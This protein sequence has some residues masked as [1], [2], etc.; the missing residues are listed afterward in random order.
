VGRCRLTEKQHSPLSVKTMWL[1]N[2]STPF[3][4]ERT[5]V[6]DQDGAEIWLVAVKGTFIIQPDGKQVLDPKQ[7][8]V[9]RIPVFR[10][11]PETSSLLYECDLLHTKSRT[12]VFVDGH[13]YG[14]KG[15]PVTCM[16]VRLKV[17]NLDKRLRVY[18]DRRWDYGLTDVI[19]SDPEPFTKVPIIYERAFGGTD[20]KSPD[21]KEHRWVAEN[22]VGKGFAT[23]KE[24]IVGQQAPNIEDPSV[25]YT[26]W[27]EGRTI[28][29]GPIARHWSPRL[30]LAGTYDE[31][32]E[33]TRKPLLPSDFD[34]LFYQCAPVD[35]QVQDFLRG[36][37]LVELWNMTESGYL[38]FRLPKVV[39]GFTTYF[40]DGTRI[41]HR[42][43]LHTVVIQPDDRRIQMVWHSKLPCH[44]KGEKLKTT[45]IYPKKRANVSMPELENGMWIEEEKW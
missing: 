38:S 18:G 19:L 10:G 40:Y 41:D 13:A 33:E 32:W 3:A 9:L 17:A 44:H 36:G 8:E 37:E 16:D 35:Q 28:G 14:P 2:N 43:D 25:P 27:L 7:E 29:F 20:V 42:A 11:K 30:K 24:H 15:K 34:E 23:K 45:H 6:R 39:L 21:P 5:W 4:A 31:V 1:L 26:N 12:D 22:P